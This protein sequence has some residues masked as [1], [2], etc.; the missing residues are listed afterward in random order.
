M[1]LRFWV[2]AELRVLLFLLD[3]LL[4]LALL[5]ARWERDEREMEMK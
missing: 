1:E 3:L 5:L 4:P 2:R